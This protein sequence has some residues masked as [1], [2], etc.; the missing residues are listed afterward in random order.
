MWRH[1]RNL[2]VQHC[3]F[4][5]SKLNC[6][7]KSSRV[8][9]DLLW[10]RLSCTQWQHR[11]DFVSWKYPNCAWTADCTLRH[12]NSAKPGERNFL[13]WLQPCHQAGHTLGCSGKLGIHQPDPT[14][15][16]ASNQA[17]TSGQP[18]LPEVWYKHQKPPSTKWIEQNREHQPD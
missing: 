4:T 6:A 16:W 5:F 12:G 17:L 15:A 13:P 3:H 8:W 14:S 11:A 10:W 9:A 1:N 2:R 18:C 7:P